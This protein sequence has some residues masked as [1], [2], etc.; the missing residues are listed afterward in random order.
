MEQQATPA[1]SALRANRQDE[2]EEYE[3]YANLVGITAKTLRDHT[4]LENW[5]DEIEISDTTSKVKLNSYAG[6][7]IME[8]RASAAHGVQTLEDFRSDFAGWQ[9]EHFSQLSRAFLRE[10]LHTLRIK[11]LQFAKDESEVRTL[12]GL[13]TGELLSSTSET[14]QSTSTPIPMPTHQATQPQGIPTYETAPRSVHTPVVQPTYE[15]PRY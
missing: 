9:Y 5:T 2:K 10:L 4:T 12:Y 7:S 6:Y 13:Y 3:M 11:G 1:P 8:L 14:S 15:I